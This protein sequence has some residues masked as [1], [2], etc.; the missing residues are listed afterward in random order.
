MF[1]AKIRALIPEYFLT[2]PVQGQVLVFCLMAAMAF[3]AKR[4]GNKVLFIMGSF[5]CALAVVTVCVE[6]FFSS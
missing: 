4:R 2:H 3:W 6:L 1:E 5:Y